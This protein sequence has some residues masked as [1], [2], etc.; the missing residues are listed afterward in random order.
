[1]D[2]S[3]GAD[4]PGG[5]DPGGPGNGGAEDSGAGDGGTGDGRPL[6]IGAFARATRLSPKALRRYDGLGV[7]R[8]DR[9]APGSGYRLYSPAQVERAR[10]V[11]SLRRL[12]MPLARVREVVELDAPRAGE[13]VR[14][15]W[16]RVEAETAARRD[17]AA[18]LVD[19]LTRTEEETMTGTLELRYAAVTDRGLSRPANQ[20]AAHAGPRVLAVADGFGPAGGAASA[21]AVGAL[22]ALDARP[23]HRD[24]APGHLG[25]LNALEDAVA[26]AVRAVAA[27]TRDAGGPGPSGTTLTALLWTGARLALVHLGD[28]RAYVL[29]GGALLRISEDHTAVAALVEDGRLTPEEALTHP[30]RSLLTRALP[31]SPDDPAVPDLRTHDTRPGDRYLVCSDG[32]G[33]VVAPERLREALSGAAAP[34]DAVRS[35]VAEAYAA[36]APD[37]VSCAVGEVVAVDRG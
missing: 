17:L 11:A 4:A 35:L 9:V 34:E 15:F 24:G 2:R 26:G 22:R 13:A 23:P 10:L 25:T 14:A 5:E 29:R 18:F 32:L 27:V 6:T 37:N 8:P 3:E 33:S 16:A 28:G 7:L 1:M 20:D 19:Q 31:G 30:G 12:G 21:A 36:G